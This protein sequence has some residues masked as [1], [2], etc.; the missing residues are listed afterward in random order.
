MAFGEVASNSND[1]GAHENHVVYIWFARYT[2]HALSD[3]WDV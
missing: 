3:A 2:V 1:C